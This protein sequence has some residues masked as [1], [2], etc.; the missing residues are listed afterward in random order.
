MNVNKCLEISF[1]PK[2]KQ[3]KDKSKNK[4]KQP[5]KVKLLLMKCL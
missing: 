5:P 3:S 4:I 1:C 2:M